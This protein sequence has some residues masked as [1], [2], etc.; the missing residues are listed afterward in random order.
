L[1]V[2]LGMEQQSSGRAYTRPRLR[3]IRPV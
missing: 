2:S 1:G 3:V